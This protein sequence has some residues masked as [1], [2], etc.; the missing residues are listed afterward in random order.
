MPRKKAGTLS[1]L[2]I[3]LVEKFLSDQYG[4]YVLPNLKASEWYRK[5]NDFVPTFL[6]GRPRAV[7]LR[8]LSRQS[9]SN[10]AIY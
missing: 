9:H 3:L 10:K 1:A 5:Y 2:V 6:W 8:Y 7:I 4:S